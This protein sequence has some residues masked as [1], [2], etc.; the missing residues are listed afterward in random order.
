MSIRSWLCDILNCNCN[1][2]NGINIPPPSP[3]DDSNSTEVLTILKAEFPNAQM[4]ISDSDYK[5]TT[6][7]ELERYLKEDI[8]DSYKYVSE[9]FDCDDFS[10]CLMGQLSNP[11]WGCLAFGIVWTKVPGG[12]HAVNCF[13]SNS[14]TVYLVE[15]QSDK[16]FKCPDNWEPFLIM[17]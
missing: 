17:M 2:G 7:K 6:K 5:T 16:I 8:T 14:G 9:Y 1:S 12:A 10:F 3:L 11:D 4:F 15:P 13:I